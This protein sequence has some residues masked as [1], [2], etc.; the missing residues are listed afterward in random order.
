MILAAIV[1]VIPFERA[2]IL[3]DV[4]PE[5]LDPYRRWALLMIPLDILWLA[6][7]VLAAPVVWRE[8]T[9]RKP[10]W[11]VIATTVVFIAMAVAYV[12][13]PN[14]LGLTLVGRAAGSIAVVAVIVRFDRSE[15]RAF[16]AAP[17]LAT[18]VLQSLLA[19]V[20]VTL[21]P[22]GG[23]ERGP[24]ISSQGTLYHP[25]VL[26]GILLA[27]ITISVAVI[28]RDRWRPL[29]LIGIGITAAG[30]PTTF[31][32]AAGLAMVLI[33]S[34]YVWGLARNRKRYTAPLLTAAVPSAF[35]SMYLWEGWVAA[36][37]RGF[38]P[39]GFDAASSGRLAMMRQSLSIA[40]HAPVTGIGPGRYLE[41]LA[42]ARPDLVGTHALAIV[43]NVPLALGAE[44]GFAIGV[45]YL[46]FLVGLGIRAFW[47]SPAASAVFGSLIVFILLDKFTYSNANMI[48]LAAVWLASLDILARPANRRESTSPADAAVQ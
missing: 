43:H 44:A 7:V 20:Q 30:I 37:A 3:A 15:F 40:R 22:V 31:S 26:A 6:F 18:A 8:W 23:I 25:Y 28:E 33:L 47:T 46:V 24:W 2:L 17:L 5:V 27:A 35:T 11:G 39:G 36:A 34:A 16:V 10:S 13:H 14:P 4:Q 38:G 32:R 19:L 9:S 48:L 41:T 21:H 45:A 1:F 42:E 29:W 12:F